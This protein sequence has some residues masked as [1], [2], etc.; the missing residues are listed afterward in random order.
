MSCCRKMQ[1]SPPSIPFI[2]PSCNYRA[3]Q[4]SACSPGAGREE[5]AWKSPTLGYRQAITPAGHP[6]LPGTPMCC[7]SVLWFRSSTGVKDHS[8][9]AS[10]ADPEL[11]LQGDRLGKNAPT[12]V[13]KLVKS[14][15]WEAARCPDAATMLAFPHCSLTLGTAAQAGDVPGLNASPTAT[16]TCWATVNQGATHRWKSQVPTSI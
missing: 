1:T 13:L 11:P 8:K 4:T 12:T 10:C 16:V 7:S 15:A 6:I 9:I 3:L 14:Q 2:S 5:P